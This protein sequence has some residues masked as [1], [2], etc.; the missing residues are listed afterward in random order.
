MHD[1]G[2]I[3][4]NQLLAI[5]EENNKAERDAMEGYYKLLDAMNRVIWSTE[6]QATL[7]L[8]FIP[9]LKEIISDEM[10]HSEELSAFAVDLSGIQ[11]AVD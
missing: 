10:N 9:Q 4:I 11:P 3:S 6:E 1:R 8:S 2:Q 7:G 5:I